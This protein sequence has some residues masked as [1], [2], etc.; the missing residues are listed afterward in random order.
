LLEELKKCARSDVKTH[1][2]EQKVHGLAHDA[3]IAGDYSLTNKCV[4]KFSQSPKGGSLGAYFKPHQGNRPF[5]GQSGLPKQQPL[6]HTDKTSG[7]TPYPKKEESFRWTHL[8][9]SGEY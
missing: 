9:L 5:Y 2:D 6:E 3:V 4:C 8:L 1:L 7:Q